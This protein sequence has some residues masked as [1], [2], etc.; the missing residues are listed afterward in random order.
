MSHRDGVRKSQR[1]N[2]CFVQV[3]A[4]DSVPALVIGNRGYRA[5]HLTTVFI[6]V[7]WGM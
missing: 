5:I 7:V 2:D 3:Y 1:E 6:S 4:V